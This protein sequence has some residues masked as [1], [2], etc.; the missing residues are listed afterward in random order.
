[1]KTIY[2]M[3]KS[4]FDLKGS[5][6]RN[7]ELDFLRLGLAAERNP[8]CLAVYLCAPLEQKVGDETV[9]SWNAK[10]GFVKP[11]VFVRAEL[12]LGEESILREEK[13]NNQ[14]GNR[15]RGGDKAKADQGR[16]IVEAKLKEFIERVH[17]IPKDLVRLRSSTFP[18]IRW[19]YSVTLPN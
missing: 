13:K 1:M 3:A 16:D 15:S 7:F 2:G 8:D 9:K 18:E 17:S 12:T 4:Y 19:D 10:Y 6:A 14:I 11:V 5:R